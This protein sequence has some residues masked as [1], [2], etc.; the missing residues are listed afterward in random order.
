MA[1]SKTLAALIGPAI[2]AIAASMLLNANSLPTL[3][4]QFSHDPALIWVSGM[5]LFVAGLAIVRAHN[6]WSGGWVVAVTVIGWL[7]LIGGLARILFPIQ[8]AAIAAEIGQNTGFIVVEAVILL[9][10]G[11]FLAIEGSRQG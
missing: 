5:I 11:G 1:T 2:M 9:A 6:V 10:I 3:I 7:L 4:G 8:L